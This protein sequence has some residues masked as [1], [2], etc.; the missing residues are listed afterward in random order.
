MSESIWWPDEAW[1][2]RKSL[3]LGF[4]TLSFR[5]LG[6]I[7]LSLGAA[8]LVSLPFNFPIAG[9]S[10]GGRAA[11]FCLVFGIGYFISSRP[12]RLV[13][14]E[15]QVVY[16]IRT[17]GLMKLRAILHGRNAKES[18]QEIENRE[19]AVH[20]IF[21]EDFKSPIPLVVSEAVSQVEHDARVQ[22]FLDE[23]VRGED[24]ISPQ[25]PRFR[26]VYRP[27]PEDIGT[28]DLIVRLEGSAVP[29]LWMRLSIKGRSAEANEAIVKIG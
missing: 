28:H 9:A 2:E 21:V 4:V 27:L 25:K 24:L 14:T 20:E 8:F 18:K 1:Y 12:V 15:L 19:P 23:Q 22:L 5:Q 17:K 7:L 29:L 6:T 26:F 10:F 16:V 13:P 3:P 11:V